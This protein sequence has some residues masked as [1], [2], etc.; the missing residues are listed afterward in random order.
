MRRLL[1][2]LA[3]CALAGAARA[4]PV[5][6]V[7]SVAITVSDLDRALAFYTEVLP[8]ELISETG[9]RGRGL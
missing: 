8:F 6:R 4:Q 3:L 9:G 2:V 1:L 5:E 7:A